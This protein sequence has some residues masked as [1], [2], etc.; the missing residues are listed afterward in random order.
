[1]GGKNSAITI[2]MSPVI[3]VPIF[4][5]NK[6]RI[7][8]VGM[9]SHSGGNNNKSNEGLFFSLKTWAILKFLMSSF[10]NEEKFVVED[11]IQNNNI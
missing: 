2:D 5:K 6:E 11:I 1:L 7:Y 4:A 3:I 10:E 9:H 8:L